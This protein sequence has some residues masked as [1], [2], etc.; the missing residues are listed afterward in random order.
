MIAGLP[1]R[2][3][4]GK[5]NVNRNSELAKSGRLRSFASLINR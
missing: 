4:A 1:E 3:T 5:Y 2:A